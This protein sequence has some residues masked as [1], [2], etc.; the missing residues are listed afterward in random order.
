[1]TKQ[2]SQRWGVRLAATLG[3]AAIGALALAAPASAVEF[4]NID[5]DATGSITLHK[6]EYQSGTGVVGDPNGDGAKLPNPIAGVGFTAYEITDLDLTVPASWDT[7]SG[8]QVPAD[9]CATPSLAGHTLGGAK[10]FADTDADG[11]TT[12]GG[13]SVGAYLICETNP[14]AGVTDIAAPFVVSVPFPDHQSDAP[15][16]TDGWIYDV[17]AYPK[18]G[19]AATISKSIDQQKDL[20]IGS[21]VTFPV[22]TS[23]PRIAD[24]NQ[25]TQYMIIDPM[26]PRLGDLKVEGVTLDGANLVE[27]TDY[28]VITEG[29]T[30]K[31]NFTQAGLAKLKTAGGKNVVTTFSGTV[32][33]LEAEGLPTGSIINEAS[34][35]T[36]NEKRTEPP[37]EP[38]T[39]P[40]LPPTPSNKVITNWGDL[41]ILK[42]DGA[43]ADKSAVLAGAKFQVF[44]SADPYAA[45]C[46]VEA[47]GD[48]IASATSGSDGVVSFAGLFVSDNVNEPGKDAESRCY[49]LVETEAPARFVLDSKPRAISV[50]TGLTNT[51]VAFD[52][53]VANTKQNV[54]D[55]PLTGANGQMLL[56]IG[57][58]ALVLFAVGAAL[59]ARKRT[60]VG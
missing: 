16:N 9:A 20:E 3:A 26:D 30:L 33:K 1:M 36:N 6:H 49:V 51:Y 34:L 59:V 48:A 25:F 40:E 31:V 13:L 56:M 4:G 24:E 15:T 27:G 17:H 44:E 18:N 52:A 43:K 53:E 38:P 55:L 19:L 14:P 5:P 46:G 42:Y 22:T 41:Q 39:D 47:T 58:G 45:D 21:K 7:L 60:Q 37:T 32:T 28:R 35:A 23:V 29:Q 50:K 8:L 10:P 11:V 54:P 2:H 57:G 12:L